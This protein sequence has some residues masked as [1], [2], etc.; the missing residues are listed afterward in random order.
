MKKAL[1]AHRHAVSPSSSE[2][3]ISLYQIR[4]DLLI[5]KRKMKRTFYTHL[6]DSNSSSSEFMVSLYQTYNYLSIGKRL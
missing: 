1:M 2:F 5:M 6:H 3:V 4:N